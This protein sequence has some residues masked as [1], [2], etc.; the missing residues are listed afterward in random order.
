[1]NKNTPEMTRTLP[2]QQGAAARVGE[3][4]A[5]LRAISKRAAW[6]LGHSFSIPWRE[7]TSQI[8]A[9]AE[10]LL[11]RPEVKHGS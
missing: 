3:L 9:E 2:P 4:E 8:L 7:G 10:K 6:L 11:R 5:G 1:M